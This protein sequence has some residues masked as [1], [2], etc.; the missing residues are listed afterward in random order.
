MNSLPWPEGE[1]ANWKDSG[2]A[3]HPSCLSCPLER[4]IEEVP[5]GRQRQRMSDRAAAMASLRRQGNTARQVAVA[6]GVSLRTVQRALQQHRGNGH[7]QVDK[8]PR[9]GNGNGGGE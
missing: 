3:L 8:K 4:C 2:C 7:R 5:R 9:R 1:Y 6:F